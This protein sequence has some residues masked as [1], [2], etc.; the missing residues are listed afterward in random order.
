M[1]VAFNEGEP[2]IIMMFILVIFLI[3]VWYFVLGHGAA[4]V[5]RQARRGKTTS[6][7]TMIFWPM[8]LFVWAYTKSA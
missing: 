5:E 3:S 2:R 7:I 1:T 4:I 6:K 8:A